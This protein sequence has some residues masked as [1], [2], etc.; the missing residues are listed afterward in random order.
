MKQ[1][2][3]E[4]KI[5][6]FPDDATDD[7]IK[8]ALG[9]DKPLDF[10]G[11]AKAHL[12]AEPTAP[13][14]DLLEML[15]GKKSTDY[16]DLSDVGKGIRA[17][18]RFMLPNTTGELARD[19]AMGAVPVSSFLKPASRFLAPAAER[20]AY[21]GL[22]PIIEGQDYGQAGK[23]AAS[24]GALESLMG[25]MGLGKG[26]SNYL[27]NRAQAIPT[28]PPVAVHQA[29]NFE[30]PLGPGGGQPPPI[31][32]NRVSGTSTPT[33]SG[34]GGSAI[35][36]TTVTVQPPRSGSPIFKGNSPAAILQEA[37]PHA[38]RPPVPPLFSDSAKA[39]VDIAGAQ[40]PEEFGLPAGIGGLSK[41]RD[42]IP[43]LKDAARTSY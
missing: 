1:V 26:V 3:F 18:G 24:V 19:V 32:F 35:T 9:G 8:A 14:P 20:T 22:Q 28:A 31:I 11:K 16:L 43:Y 2:N 12:T 21:A 25:V 37:L 33:V 6:T 29:A 42:L 39:V 13:R 34:G 27:K 23:Q 7:E 17:A 5:H 41:L 30:R 15:T 10:V 38:A 40:N 4:G 36:P